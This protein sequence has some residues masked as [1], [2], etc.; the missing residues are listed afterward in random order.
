MI[1]VLQG[2][3]WFEFIQ[4]KRYWLNQLVGIISFYAIFLFLFFGV[5]FFGQS[6]S[7]GTTLE[8]IIIGFWVFMLVGFAYQSASAL[9]GRNI[10]M[11]TLEHLH[12]S[13]YGFVS[14][15]FG[16]LIGNFIIMLLLYVPFLLLMMLTT[17][18]WLYIDLISIV[19]L[20]C[21][22]VL[23]AFG[24]GF[25]IGGLR[26]I[27]KRISSL[28][29]PLNLLFGVCIIMPPDSI[30]AKLLPFNTLWRLLRDVMTDGDSIFHL[31]MVPLFYCLIQT[32]V[33]LALGV[34]IYNWCDSI[35]KNKGSIGQY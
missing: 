7:L 27:H 33:I 20:L 16:S 8:S 29:E 25:I 15:S 22:I 10:S 9:I 24:I 2:A 21:G 17:G 11:G 26:L 34:F 1:H 6:A 28:H 4:A 30:I 13:P 23:Q 18:K 35:T 14:I 19:P 12:L 32:I 31:P 3:I 5:Q